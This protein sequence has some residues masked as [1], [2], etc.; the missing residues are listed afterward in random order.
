MKRGVVTKCSEDKLFMFENE[1]KIVKSQG[2]I[3]WAAENFKAEKCCSRVLL[4][5]RKALQPVCAPPQ[6]P[7]RVISNFSCC[8]CGSS[9][10]KVP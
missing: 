10:N 1:M 4:L 9:V 7:F 5:Y 6:L 3:E 2:S 8:G